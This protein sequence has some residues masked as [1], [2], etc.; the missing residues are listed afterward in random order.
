MS[1]LTRQLTD[2]EREE[3]LTSRYGWIHDDGVFFD[4]DGD[5]VEEVFETLDDILEFEFKNGVG[6]GK[7]DQKRVVRMA[8][9]LE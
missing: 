2:Q 7:Y 1:I 3:I 9:G 6:R 5:E 4:E 8:L